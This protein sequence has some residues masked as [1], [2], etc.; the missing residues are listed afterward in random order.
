MCRSGAEVDRGV[1]DG[2]TREILLIVL[3]L[4]VLVVIGS[5]PVGAYSEREENHEKSS[6]IEQLGVPSLREDGSVA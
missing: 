2:G 4:V 5:S 1:G 3:V 6:S